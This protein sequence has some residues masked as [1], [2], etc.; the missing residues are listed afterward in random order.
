MIVGGWNLI[1]FLLGVNVP[2][3]EAGESDSEKEENRPSGAQSVYDY[4]NITNTADYAIRDELDE[5]Q[6]EINNV[7]INH[8]TVQFSIK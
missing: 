7:S 5:A 1:H 4:V 6:R 2:K 3:K 8:R